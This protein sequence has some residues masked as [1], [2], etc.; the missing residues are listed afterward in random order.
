MSNDGF[1]EC[2]YC[3][4]DAWLPC[5]LK[6]GK[7]YECIREECSHSTLLRDYLGSNDHRVR[8]LEHCVKCDAEREVRLFFHNRYPQRTEWEWE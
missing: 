5:E 2:Q 7:C 4:G 1:V 6:D 3:G 8:F